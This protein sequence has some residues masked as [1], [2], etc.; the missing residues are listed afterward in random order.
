MPLGSRKTFVTIE[1]PCTILKG[2]S[3]L[4]CNVKKGSCLILSNIR[5]SLKIMVGN[6]NW[7]FN[8]VSLVV[9]FLLGWVII[10]QSLK[11]KTFSSEIIIFCEFNEW[12]CIKKCQNKTFKYNFRCQELSKFISSAIFNNFYIQK[13]LIFSASSSVHSKNIFPLSKYVVQLQ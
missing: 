11:K 9:E 2:F 6:F 8:S 4:L 13:H 10:T 3:V 12:H 7:L 1:H 5:V